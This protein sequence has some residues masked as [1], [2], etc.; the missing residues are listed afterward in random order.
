MNC[1]KVKNY[2]LNILPWPVYRF[3]M[4]IRDKICFW[5]KK[6]SF[7]RLI[8]EMLCD[9]D[10][11]VRK[12]AV[13]MKKNRSTEPFIGAWTKKYLNFPL[14]MKYDTVCKRYY[15]NYPVLHGKKRLY[16]SNQISK[17]QARVKINKLRMEQDRLSPHRYLNR[18]VIKHIINM[19]GTVLDLGSAE[20]NFAL[21]IV[22]FADKVYCFDPDKEWIQAMKCTFS[23]YGDKVHYGEYFI[24]DHGSRHNKIISLDEFF[25]G[26][27]EFLL[28]FL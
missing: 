23:G 28:M 10:V 16:Y 17:N 22:D 24:S 2:L 13:W 14:R 7:S 8:E 11:D 4:K 21:S 26:G 12:C 20:G 27:V 9:S 6:E 5:K 19:R 18:H 25:E 3:Q 15:C 1:I